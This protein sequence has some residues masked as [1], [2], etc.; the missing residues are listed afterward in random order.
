MSIAQTG[1]KYSRL[2]PNSL[3]LSSSITTKWQTIAMGHVRRLAGEYPEARFPLHN[4]IIPITPGFG[5]Q[6]ID[7]DS[8]KGSVVPE[9]ITVIPAN[10]VHSS[11]SSEFDMIGIGLNPS[12][13][14]CANEDA[15]NLKPTE[16]LPQFAM[17]DPLVYQL[18]LSL[19]NVLE[20]DPTGSRLYAE[21]TATM[22]T[23]HLLQHYGKQRLEFKDY[24][25]G[26]ARSTLRQVV[27]Y[28]QENLDSELGLAEL[29]AV[30]HLSPHYFTR[31]FKQSTG[32]TP[33]QFVIRCRVE[34]AKAL[35][36]NG[37]GSISEIAQQVGF[38]NQ[39]H[40]NVHIK[41]SLGVTPKMILEQRKNR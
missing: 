36:L 14:E 22:L 16:L 29:A 2:F 10:V 27:D 6:I 7:G 12:L 15:T 17:P 1:E 19:K 8:K 40:L 26:L 41:R 21:T 23:V 20:R 25:D 9:N 37:S 5:E 4:I 28:I 32:Q 38:A 33:H 3:L 13:F 30:A 35:L 18:G 24:T 31:L 39:A 11:R 34:R